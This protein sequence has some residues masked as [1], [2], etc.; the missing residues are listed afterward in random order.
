MLKFGVVRFIVPCFIILLLAIKCK[1]APKSDV[2]SVIQESYDQ[3]DSCMNTEY[4]IHDFEI[5]K[6]DLTPGTYL[7]LLNL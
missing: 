7:K 1:E 6:R 4:T 5:N 3:I 2:I